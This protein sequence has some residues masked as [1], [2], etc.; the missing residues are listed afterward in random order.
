MRSPSTDTVESPLSADLHFVR[1]GRNPDGNRPVGGLRMSQEFEHRPVLVDEVVAALVGVPEGLLVDAT[2]GAGGH[3]RALLSAAPQLRLLGLDRDPDAVAAASA[4]LTPLFGPS[5]VTVR[6]ARFDMIST[7][8]AALADGPVTAVFFDL[9]VSSPQLD[10]PERGFSYR[11]QGPLDMRMD[12]TSTLTAADVV[13]EY[14]ESTLAALFAA[15]GEGRFAG[16]IARAIVAARPIEDTVQLADIIKWAIPAPARRRGG[17]PAKRVFQAIRIEVNDELEVLSAALDSAL[18]ALAPNGRCAVLAYH[19]GEDR[20]VKERFARA[21]RGGCVCPPGMP[22]MCGATPDFQL[23][24][25]GATKATAVE[26]A[27]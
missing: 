6:H 3:S 20:I 26:I 13:N 5:R 21:A 2:V 11:A 24:R 25:R 17:H 14:S 22:C 18:E 12:P 10:R 4:L 23:V 9:G 19:S 27:T 1:S 7:A 16:R 8:V 15:N